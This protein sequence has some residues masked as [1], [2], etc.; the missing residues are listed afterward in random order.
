MVT[1]RLLHRIVPLA[2]LV[3]A[4][5][6][7]QDKAPIDPVALEN[8]ARAGDAKAM[9][10]LADLLGHAE[11]GV[12]DQVYPKIVALVQE[13]VPALLRQADSTN[14]IQ[15]EYTLAALGTLRA[16]EAFD[17]LV[18]AL[19]DTGFERRYIAA[20]ALGQLGDARGVAPLI[21][22]LNDDNET[23]RRYATRSL[24]KLDRHAVEPMIAA[25]PTA[26]T[27]AAGYLIRAL[28]DIGDARAVEPLLAQVS[29]PNRP[30]VF[31]ALA[32]LKDRRAEA[33]LIEG[34]KDADWRSRSFAAMA[35]GP[36]G[37]PQSATALEPLLDDPEVVVREWAARSLEMITG[38][39]V[40]YRDAKGELVLPY[41]IYH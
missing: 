38:K 21:A 7:C 37:S 10:R 32:K 25:L 34:L 5:A 30:L 24:I 20:W 15:R 31:Q 39:H 16:R 18:A 27:R 13:A 29:G 4:L 23:V 9:A 28:G 12:N 26:T 40:R 1:R 35:L 33:A 3:L 19:E 6:G 11:N 2:A 8:A 22:A 17:A 36:L 14:A 41:S